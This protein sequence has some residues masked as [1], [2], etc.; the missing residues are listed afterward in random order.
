M[1]G[2]AVFWLSLASPIDALGQFLLVAHMTQ[3]LALMSV[4]PPLIVLGAPTVPLL[5]GLPRLWIRSDLS[6]WMTSPAVERLRRFLMHPLFGWLSMNVAFLG[7]HV[8]AAYELALRSNA[9]HD[10]EHGCFF[11][12][13]L[14]FW[15]FVV[16]PWPSHSSWPR[17]AVLPYLASADLVNTLLSA[18]LSF[19]GRVVYPTYAAVPRLFGISPLDD[20]IAAGPEM[21]V[22]GSL[23]FLVPAG[24]VTLQLLHPRREAASVSS[25]GL[26]GTVS[27]GKA[28]FDLLHLPLVG[29]LLRSRYGRIA[30]QTLSLLMMSL[31][32]VDGLSGTPLSSMNLAGLMTW[33]VIRPIGLIVLLFAGNLF[34]MACPFTLPRELARALGIARLQWPR[35]MRRKWIAFGLMVLFFWAYEQF[36]LWDSPRVTALVLVAYI[37]TA[38]VVDSIF[39]GGNFCKYVCPVG[40]FNFVTSLISPLELGVKKLDTCNNCSTQD[41]IRG[42][43]VQ[44]GC[45]L[46]LY[47][48][49]KIGNIDCTMCMDCVKACPNDNIQITLQMPV[50]DLVNDPARSSLGRL[51]SRVDIAIL[52]LTV[53]F[54]A[55]LNA[56]LMISPIGDL[57]AGLTQRLPA[58]STMPMSL[59]GTGLLCVSIL[60]VFLLQAMV[61]SL[62]SDGQTTRTIFCR[63]ALAALPLGLAMWVAHLGFHLATST[64]SLLPMFRHAYADLAS[65]LHMA[66]LGSSYK[67]VDVMAICRPIDLML[68]PGSK[69]FSVLS[70]QVWTLDVGLLLSLYAGWRICSQMVDSGRAKVCMF[71]VWALGGSMMYA[72]CVWVCT[73]PMQMRGM[74]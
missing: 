62:F 4:A 28:P 73:Q 29:E 68:M 26:P 66:S 31:V 21:W 47:L 11:F 24:I 37:G 71:A 2:L 12:S 38:L 67:A 74:G 3:H 43:T 19:C 30:L 5:R 13:S 6:V 40:Q 8:P 14:L 15:W 18:F 36:K 55:L 63:F 10:V 7:W 1:G 51:S 33:N 16:Q 69:G 17:W 41:C 45:E 53:S 58:V 25:A 22:I 60:L 64:S 70:L 39:R 59:L 72:A 32:I 9:W 44:R 54:A 35:W 27:V 61:M 65:G 52:A 50:R 46:Q 42:N 48:P 56:A 49:N 23:I 20:Q 57:L 34:C